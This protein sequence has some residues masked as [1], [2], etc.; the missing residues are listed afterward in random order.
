MRRVIATIAI[1]AGAVLAMEDSAVAQR[2]GV[3]L[4][5]RPVPGYQQADRHNPRSAGYAD[6]LPSSGPRR[7]AGGHHGDRHH[8][9]GGH[10]HHGGDWGWDDGA[11]GGY[12][13]PWDYGYVPYYGGFPYG[14]YGGYLPPVIL[15][16]DDLL[17]S[18]RLGWNP[19]F[20]PRAAPQINV[21][22]VEPPEVDP[23][24]P[25]EAARPRVRVANAAAEER[26]RKWLAIGDRYFEQQRYRQ[27]Y[28]RYKEAAEAAPNLAEAY[29]RQ[30]QAMVAAAQYEL[31]AT[32]FQ[33]YLR[34]DDEMADVPFALADL[35]VGQDA[36]QTAHL[37]AL[38]VEAEDHPD[39]GDLLL[40]VGMQ[41]HYGGQPERARPFLERAATLIEHRDA[42]VAAGIQRLMAGGVAAAEGEQVGVHF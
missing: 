12:G 3:P 18:S 10:H 38:A 35:Y 1:A 5:D 19:D 29:L 11:W 33:R 13:Y 15:T 30:A 31:A 22:V 7:V 27:A 25:L 28:Q 32:A 6:F 21:V 42:V 2:R 23:A 4:I 39:D 26:G 9:H 16:F 20:V 24:E 17:A 36:A 14:Y 37:E 34:L 41:L 8:Q 40:L